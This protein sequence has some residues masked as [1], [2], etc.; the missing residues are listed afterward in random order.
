METVE[1]STDT[2]V[3]SSQSSESAYT[4]STT[5]ANVIAK[6]K[7]MVNIN[8]YGL[9]VGDNADKLATRA[10][11]L[12]R[13]YCSVKY[14]SWT[15]VPDNYKDDVWLKLTQEFEFNV[16]NHLAKPCVFRTLPQKFRTFKYDLRTGP[17]LGKVTMQEKLYACPSNYDVDFWRIFVENESKVGVKEKH[18]NWFAGIFSSSIE[19]SSLIRK[20]HNRSHGSKNNS[21]Q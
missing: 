12:V 20:Y 3:S 8:E 7:L 4:S 17:L 19:K 11:K 16:P 10:G 5:Q 2:N 21:N 18:K 9:L 13:T 15:K 6:P 1:A 14:V